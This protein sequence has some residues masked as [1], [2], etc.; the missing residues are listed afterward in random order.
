MLSALRDAYPK[1]SNFIT[2]HNSSLDFNIV[3]ASRAILLG[4]NRS[5]TSVTAR[6]KQKLAQLN[7]DL[8]LDKELTP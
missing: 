7:S 4:R 3:S 8:G 1:H 6:T 2:G 5:T